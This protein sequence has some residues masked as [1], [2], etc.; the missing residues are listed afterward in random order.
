MASA[1]QPPA[2]LGMHSRA[3]LE[4]AGLVS[5]RL[6]ER[7][8]VAALKHRYVGERRAPIGLRPPS[9][10]PYAPRL[11]ETAAAERTR[12]SA[13]MDRLRGTRRVSGI[14][15][16][17]REQL[18]ELVAELWRPERQRSPTQTQ[19]LRPGSAAGATAAQLRRMAANGAS[20]PSGTRPPP[21]RAGDAA[22]ELLEATGGGSGRGRTGGTG[23]GSEQLP[24]VSVNDLDRLE[25]VGARLA[26]REFVSRLTARYEGSG[27]RV[28]S[29]PPR[30]QQQAS[31]GG[32][33]TAAAAAAAARGHDERLDLGE[34]IEETV[35]RLIDAERRR[36]MRS[37][38]EKKV[39]A[40]LLNSACAPRAQRDTRPHGRCGRCGGASQ[41][42]PKPPPA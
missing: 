2:G 32:G 6:A 30:P 12:R 9:D 25:L 11:N 31:G 3:E 13:E 42:W 14:D 1:A 19:M 15:D 4:A 8:F 23:A 28:S 21:P 33:V 5:K 41:I 18:A 26:D 35:A 36:E 34:E 24:D 38:E 37:L 39:V 27:D 10:R 7:D 17:Y 22:R 29:V 40:A 20:D 16:G